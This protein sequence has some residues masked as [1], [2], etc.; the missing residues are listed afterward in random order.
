M[1]LYEGTWKLHEAVAYMSDQGFEISN[2]VPV[3]YD[4]TDTVSLIEVDCVFR[5]R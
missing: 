3:N 5:R 2:I 4:H 1:H